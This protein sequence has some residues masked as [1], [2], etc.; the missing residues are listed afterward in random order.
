MSYID[1]IT[2]KDTGESRVIS[3]AAEAVRV[4]NENYEGENLDEVLDEV[5]HAIEDAG[6]GDGTVTG[7]KIGS[8]TYEPTDGVV[9]L[10]SP[11]SNK[12]DKET[13]KGLSTNDYTTAEKTKLGSLPTNPV[14]TISVNGGTPQS[15]VNGNVNISVEGAAGEDGITPHIGSNGN[16]WIGD[17]DTNVKA[18]GPAGSVTITDGDIDT[19]EVHNALN[20][21]TG[22]LGMSGAMRI[23]SNIDSLYTSLNRLYTKLANMAFWDSEDQ[24]DAAPTPL[25][26]SIPQITVTLDKTSLSANAMITDASDQEISGTSVSVDEGS[27]LTLKIKPR[28]GYAITTASATIGGVSQTLTESNGVY[29]LVLDSVTEAITIVIS[30][31]AAQARSVT[32]NLTGC[33]KTSGP[34]SIINGGG[35]TFVFAAETDYTLPTA[36]PTV[37]GASIATDG[38]DSSSG[39]LVIENVTGDVTITIAAT[40][41]APW[42]TAPKSDYSE[43]GSVVTYG[44]QQGRSINPNDGYATAGVA[45]NAPAIILSPAAYPYSEKIC[46]SS[47]P[48]GL[49]DDNTN[50][51]KDGKS[52]FP[53]GGKRYLRVM[54]EFNSSETTT[55]NAYKVAVGCYNASTNSNA[56]SLSNYPHVGNFVSRIQYITGNVTTFEWVFDLHTEATSHSLSAGAI[57]YI[58]LLMGKFVGGSSTATDSRTWIDNMTLKYKFTDD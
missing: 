44:M 40:Y 1:K 14:Q 6:S 4:S 45:N 5:A 10:S 39:E 26:W 16:W 50:P 17:T 35:G 57:T 13:G 32:L 30:A 9:D 8:T 31:T 33:T 55:G 58:K 34:T 20:A 29:T 3:P 38:W 37:V 42:L 53:T 19:L 11:M 46:S 7:V 15:P 56:D 12:V 25:D 47:N 21:S 36:A 48:P 2:N 18:Q 28:N 23:K 41:V 27:G 43:G 22:I 51:G 24:E 54:M 49:T 52:Y